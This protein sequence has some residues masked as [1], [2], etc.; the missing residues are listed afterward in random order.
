[1]D[2]KR[3]VVPE[4][5]ERKKEPEDWGSMTGFWKTL[6]VTAIVII[7][8]LCLAVVFGG[9]VLGISILVLE[10]LSV[11]SAVICWMR[12]IARRQRV[13][14]EKLDRLLRERS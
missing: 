3:P 7:S 5:T 8:G 12:N 11:V 1:M 14:E 4:E 13:I 2:E 10:V 6:A 9:G